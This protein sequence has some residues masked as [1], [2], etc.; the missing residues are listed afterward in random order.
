MVQGVARASRGP[1]KYTVVWDGLDDKGKPLPAGTYTVRIESAREKG[2]HINMNG[3]IECGA[4]ASSA[5]IEDSSD[6]R[7]V[8]LSYGPKEAKP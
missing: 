3:K 8:N 2:A 1:G 7:D 6:I 5:K 4:K